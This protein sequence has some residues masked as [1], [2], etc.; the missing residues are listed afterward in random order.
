[1]MDFKKTIPPTTL[2]LLL[3][4]QASALN[5]SIEVQTLMSTL[6]ENATPL[7]ETPTTTDLAFHK[8]STQ[9]GLLGD[10]SFNDYIHGVYL[11]DYEQDSDM[12][13]SSRCTFYNDHIRCNAVWDWPTNKIAVLKKTVRGP[14]KLEFEWTGGGSGDYSHISFYIDGVQKIKKT[15]GF[16]WETEVYE[17]PEGIHELKWYAYCG[18]SHR[19]RYFKVKPKINPTVITWDSAGDKTIY[20]KLPKNAETVNSLIG[21]NGPSAKKPDDV[22]TKNLGYSC[23]GE[24][25]HG[26]YDCEGCAG[27]DFYH[28]QVPGSES[29]LA[30]YTITTTGCGGS[31]S[32]NGEAIQRV[33]CHTPSGDDVY[34]RIY[35]YDSYYERYRE[36][37]NTV[38]AKTL[39]LVCDSIDV[40]AW[41]KGYADRYYGSCSAGSCDSR[42]DFDVSYELL[43]PTNFSV[44]VGGWGIY[45]RSGDFTGST[46]LSNFSEHVNDY[47]KNCSPDEGGYCM[48]PLVFHSDSPGQ[49]KV[50]EINVGYKKKPVE[51]EEHISL[52][53]SCTSRDDDCTSY[54]GNSFNPRRSPGEYLFEIHTTISGGISRINPTRF[55]N[56]LESY[57]RYEI[58]C[59]KI[60]G[61]TQTYTSS[62]NINR[63]QY[64]KCTHLNFKVTAH[65]NSAGGSERTISTIEAEIN[66]RY[67]ESNQYLVFGSELVAGVENNVSATIRNSGSATGSFIASL[68]VDGI[69]QEHKI[70]NLTEGESRDLV[71][72]Y[73]PQAGQ[74]NVSITANLLS[75]G[76]TVQELFTGNNI[77]SRLVT[78]E[79]SVVES[80]PTDSA[81][82]FED[83]LLSVAG[84]RTLAV[85]CSVSRQCWDGFHETTDECVDGVCTHYCEGGCFPGFDYAGEYT[86]N[87]TNLEEGDTVPVSTTVYNNGELDANNFL[88]TLEDNGRIVDYRMISLEDGENRE[89]EF[90]WTASHGSHVLSTV[91]D[92]L[93]EPDGVIP[94]SREDNNVMSTSIVVRDSPEK[95]ALTDLVAYWP[96]DEGLGNS[97][98]DYSGNGNHGLVSGASWTEGVSDSALK[99]DGIDDYVLVDDKGNSFGKTLC[100][101]GCSFSLWIKPDN[102]DRNQRILSR[103]DTTGLDRFF[104]MYINAGDY[105]FWV[106]GD[107]D[108]TNISVSA[109]HGDFAST[110]WHHLVGTFN[111]S[112]TQAGV[113]QLYVDGKLKDTSTKYITINETAWQ[114]DETVFLGVRD[115]SSYVDYLNGSIDEIRIYS[116]ALSPTEIEGL[117]GLHRGGPLVAAYYLDEGFGSVANDSSGNENHGIIHGAS[118]VDGFSN[119][120]TLK[121]SNKLTL[122]AWVKLGEPLGSQDNWA[123]VFSKY[124]SGAEGSGYYLEMRGYDNRTVCA[125]RDASHT[126]HQVYAV[127]EPF[128]LGWHQITCTYN[129]SRQILY[130]DGVEKASAEWSGNLSH[131]TLPLR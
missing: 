92:P 28:F 37:K 113:T 61:S 95:T 91:I 44:D 45:S 87:P 63:T 102:L 36:L 60:D 128:D 76:V 77:I 35:G 13:T 85:G 41:C 27:S 17:I 56:W 126:Y 79:G 74:H 118:W 71:F 53:A 84:Q 33:V 88:V 73:T 100:N 11:L 125:M 86:L 3:I 47:L 31:G 30:R 40:E 119:H 22:F 42:A 81:A 14:A 129:G 67:N 103:Y 121:P 49:V 106:N 110:G 32:N 21:L 80:K 62:G 64:Y 108:I 34:E 120:T 98:K 93:P 115:D 2:I 127:D 38:C 12:W 104:C 97:V 89:V 117:F 114:D 58:T 66:I 55:G 94:E 18:G 75:D 112:T 26:D 25:D 48:V 54:Q 78:V 111:G 99:F 69:P 46:V 50:S 57:R 116:R 130:I 101:N 107:G 20:L 96:M 52:Y 43:F 70:I 90:S 15:T 68:L 19:D 7:G 29:N 51:G 105:F 10:L 1:M 124:V 123:G 4:T 5:T 109:T 72:N 8:S 9:G 6:L 59:Y 24:G 39:N 65:A 23:I 131:N 122:S 82:S 83:V 16:D